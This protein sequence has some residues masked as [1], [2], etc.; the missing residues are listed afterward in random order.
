M[1]ADLV[2]VMSSIQGEGLYVG[3]RQ[4]FMRFLGCNLRCPYCDTPAS[5]TEVRECRIEKTPGKRDFVTLPNPMQPEMAASILKFY[6]LHRHHSVSL[7]GGE[8]L[9]RVDFLLELI[10]LIRAQG[11][12]R[13]FLETNGTLPGNLERLIDE[14]DI[15]S[16]DIKLTG[17]T[18][19]DA[20]TEFLQVAKRKEVY[21]KTVILAET[22]NADFQQTVDLI[23]AVDRNVPL[24]LQP[25]TPYGSIRRGPAPVRLIELQDMATQQLADVRVIPQTHKIMGQL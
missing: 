22:T 8:P 14:L 2:E 10:P 25:V 20:H 5:F 15:V 1:P 12:Q 23:A 11:A 16:M 24:V 4:V 9:L 21:V 6:D 7:T 17:D 18:D 3:T 13:I 19:W